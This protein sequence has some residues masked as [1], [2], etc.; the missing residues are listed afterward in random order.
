MNISNPE[1]QSIIASLISG[2]YLGSSSRYLGQ[3][4]E[5]ADG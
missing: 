4:E 5:G 2:G 3:E 1:R